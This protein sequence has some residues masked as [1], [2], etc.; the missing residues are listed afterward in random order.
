MF[1]KWCTIS[2]STSR[3]SSDMRRTFTPIPR[4]GGHRLSHI[5]SFRRIRMALQVSVV[6]R[7]R[8]P[9]LSTVRTPCAVSTR[10]N[11]RSSSPRVT[12]T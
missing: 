9:P 12:P 10:R 3:I 1:Q 11:P 6:Y 2:T 8:T 5:R 7:F 4:N